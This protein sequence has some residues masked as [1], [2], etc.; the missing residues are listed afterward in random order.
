[1]SELRNYIERSCRGSKDLPYLINEGG[2]DVSQELRTLADVHYSLRLK[3]HESRA[4]CISSNRI[5]RQNNLSERTGTAVEW[6]VPFHCDNAVGDNELD[7]NGRAYIKNAFLNAL[8]VE[9][10]LGPAVPRARHSA[11][12]VLH[13]DSHAGPVM[14]FDF[15]HGDH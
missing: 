11:E 12:H 7:R 14:S 1:M 15:W 8:P 10:I 6:A 4:G 9:N 2:R 5:V 3:A 13:T